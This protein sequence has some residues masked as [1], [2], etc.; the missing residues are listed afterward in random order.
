MQIDWLTVAA[1]I[2]NF[3]ALIWLLQRFLYRPITNAMARR[4]ARIEERISDAKTRRK[5]A[6]DEAERLRKKREE[7]EDS[8]QEMLHEARV[9]ADALKQRLEKDIRD[10][11]EQKRENWRDM[12]EAE[13]ADFVRDMQR[14]AGHKVLDIAGQLV[15]E[16]TAGALDDRIAQG[17]VDQLKDLDADTRE[18]MAAA[19]DGA[20]NP[21][22]VE[23]AAAL[24]TAGRRKITRAIHEVFET[25]IGVDYGKDDA[26]LLGVRLSI[27]EQ[28]V[29]WSA[30]RHLNRLNRELDALLDSASPARGK[31]TTD[32]Q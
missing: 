4:E 24:E 1:Q 32:E 29:E 22:L 26:M 31:Q 23:T 20:D 15:A 5:E 21:A 2:I 8:T 14:L 28:T 27:S 11:V 3:L 18:K 10:E 17:F 12:L 9:E 30:A 6:E 16:F 7:L 25:N 19:A 13:R